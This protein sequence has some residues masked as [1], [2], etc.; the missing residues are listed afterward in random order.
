MARNQN[1]K[2]ERVTEATLVIGVDI[3]KQKH[4]AR[5]VDW[6]GLELGTPLFFENTREGLDR[7]LACIVLEVLLESYDDHLMRQRDPRR[8]RLVHT[9]TR[10]VLTSLG[11]LRIRRRYYRDCETGRRVYLLDEALGLAPRRRVSDR[12]HGAD[13]GFGH[14]DVLPPGGENSPDLGAGG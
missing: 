4:V 3:A 2:I 13:G 7:W 8:W 5:C 11:P 6:R 14:G 10:T 12:L 9:K 1:A